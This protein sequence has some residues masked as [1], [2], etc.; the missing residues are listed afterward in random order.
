[1]ALASE[2]IIRFAV[3]GVQ[4]SYSFTLRDLCVNAADGA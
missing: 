1:V 4:Q 2:V 3:E